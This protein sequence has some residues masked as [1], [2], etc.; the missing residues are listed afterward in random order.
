MEPPNEDQRPDGWSRGAASYEELFAPF[1]GAYADD[2]IRLLDVTEHDRVLDI[3]AGSGAF[4]T[5]A[6][7]RGASVLATDFAPGMLEVLNALIAECGL[8]KL[9]TAVMDGQAL[10]VEDNTFDVAGSMF[11]LIFFPDLDAGMREMARV[12]RPGGRLA[13]SSWDLQGFGMLAMIGRAIVTVSPEV[14]LPTQPPPWARL[15]A[16]DTLP[17]SLT[18]AGWTDVVI[19]TVDHPLVIPDP[20]AFFHRLGEWS[21]PARVVLDRIPDGAQAATAEAFA[22]EVAASGGDRITTTALIGTG[23]AP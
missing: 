20:V 19:H 3:G 4:T 5:R 11:G 7:E 15:G 21:I 13:I 17:A 1:T 14:E 22:A 23:I 9:T 6:A 2:A 8:T 10:D 12:V 18:A 16:P